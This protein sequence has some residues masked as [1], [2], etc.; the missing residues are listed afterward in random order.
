MRLHRLNDEDYI[1][2]E[3]GG[4]KLLPNIGNYLPTDITSYPKRPN[5]QSLILLSHI[6]T[7]SVIFFNF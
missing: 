2:S 6:L 1:H 4:R 5:L 7:E 3:Y